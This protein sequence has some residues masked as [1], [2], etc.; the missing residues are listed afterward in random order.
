MLEILKKNSLTISIKDELLIKQ[1]LEMLGDKESRSILEQ[2]AKKSLSVP[3]ILEICKLSKTSGY[4][5]INNLNRNGY[6]VRTGFEL[7]S[8]K[9]AVDK[10]TMFWEKIIIEMKEGKY[11]VKIKISKKIFNSSSVIQVIYKN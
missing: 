11:I 9:R 6:L 8:K 3:E 2:V 7:T 4:R 10:Y 5:K 1:I